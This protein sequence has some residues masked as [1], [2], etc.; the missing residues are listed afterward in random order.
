MWV[1]KTRALIHAWVTPRLRRFMHIYSFCQPDLSICCEGQ[2]AS[3]AFRSFKESWSNP[4]WGGDPGGCVRPA[5][6]SAVLCRKW[7]KRKEQT[8]LR[9]WLRSRSRGSHR[10]PRSHIHSR[11]SGF[12]HLHLQSLPVRLQVPLHSGRKRIKAG[13]LLKVSFWL[14]IWNTI[15]S[16]LRKTS[17]SIE[18][19]PDL[20]HQTTLQSHN[21]E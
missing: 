21:C 18:S 14:L 12:K 20:L 9:V 16:K 13:Y 6:P 15:S 4:P 8:E 5:N 17:V 10:A 11:P 7:R 1:R 3:T 19:F 2:S